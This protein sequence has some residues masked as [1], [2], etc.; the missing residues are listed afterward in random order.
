[1]QAGK[2]LKKYSSGYIR[3]IAAIRH[4]MWLA[5]V[6]LTSMPGL[7]QRKSGNPGHQPQE[8][9][10]SWRFLFMTY[11]KFWDLN[12]AVIYSSISKKS[13]FVLKPKL[14][15]AI[16]KLVPTWDKNYAEYESM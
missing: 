1:M 5:P 8:A 13:P 14:N 3:Y 10:L 7:Y 6:K 2:H 4:F 9:N 12:F 16:S 11:I 15:I